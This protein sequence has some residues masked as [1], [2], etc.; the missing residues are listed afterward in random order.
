[1]ALPKFEIIEKW[2]NEQ[3]LNVI[4]VG[5]S[6]NFDIGLGEPQ[7]EIDE[8]VCNLYSEKEHRKL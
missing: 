2:T 5:E 4:R 1:M 8:Y 3:L 7:Q 6:L